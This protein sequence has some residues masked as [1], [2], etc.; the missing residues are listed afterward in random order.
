[1]KVAKVDW[2]DRLTKTRFDAIR[3]ARE[4][5]LAL[6]LPA[7]KYIANDDPRPP[8][9]PA[10]DLLYLVDPDIRKPFDMAEVISRLVDDSRVSTFKPSFGTNLITA[11]AQI[12]GMPATS[13]STALFADPMYTGHNVGIVANRIPV[14][15]GDEASKGAQFIRQC[16]QS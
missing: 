2:T 3:K 11:F 12:F 9:H 13:T 7:P 16:N 15:H 10:E 14:I 8:R 1:V 6:P 5:V 4:W